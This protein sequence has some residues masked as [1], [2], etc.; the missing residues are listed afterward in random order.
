MN[1]DASIRCVPG[2]YA[3]VNGVNGHRYI[4]SSQNLRYRLMGHLSQLRRGVHH[5]QPLQRA[6]KKYGAEAFRFEILESCEANGIY[7]I[8][9]RW[10]DIHKPEYNV[11]PVAVPGWV[12]QKHTPETLERMCAAQRTPEARERQ[13]KMQ[14]G[15]IGRRHTEET[16][17]KMSLARRGKPLS[18][19]AKQHLREF[20][21]EHKYRHSPEIRAR[22]SASKTGKKNSP[23]AIER[24]RASLTGR[25]LSEE[26]RENIGAGLRGKTRSHEV[27]EAVTKGI[28]R[29]DAKRLAAGEPARVNTKRR[30]DAKLTLKQVSEMRSLWVPSDSGARRKKTTGPTIIEIAR[31]FSVSYLTAWKA[32][33]K[34]QRA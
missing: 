7:D 29:A 4:G 17:A 6:W 32:I 9:Q 13:R 8:E 12:G 23:E 24:M 33:R 26:H 25:K 18:E 22:I 11:K 10:L 28:R 31:R 15:R 19:E 34:E 27:R 3:I 5:A 14:Q 1:L 30:K 20:A 21:A 16:K 2:V